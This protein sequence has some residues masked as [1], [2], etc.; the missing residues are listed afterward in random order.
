[1]KVAVFFTCERAAAAALLQQLRERW[2][3]AHVVAYANDEDREP[4]ARCHPAVEFRR[5]KPAGG[6]A[7]FVKALRAAGFDR[8]VVAW[9]GG[10][11]F[12]PLR[13]VALLLD[14]PVL[15]VDERGRERVVALWRPWTW[16]PHLLR[17]GLT[18]DPL[19]VARCAAACYRATIGLVLAVV[20]LPL[21]LL[22]ARVGRPGPAA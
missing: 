15:A 13:L 8:V 18:A 4:L 2:P 7:A 1:M 5:D 16:G 11:R 12:Q 10:E 21:R 17:R 22:L 3:D 14:R 20:W 19:F 9:H 6:K